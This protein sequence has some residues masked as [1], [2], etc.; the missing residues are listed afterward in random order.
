MYICMSIYIISLWSD[1]RKAFIWKFG[2]TIFHYLCDPCRKLQ[3][4]PILYPS[5][6][7]STEEGVLTVKKLNSHKGKTLVYREIFLNWRDFFFLF[8]RHTYLSL[9]GKVQ[10]RKDSQTFEGI[11]S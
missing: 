9:N 11:C 7:E 4:W 1:I 3:I 2:V 5:A 10:F 6:D 8:Q